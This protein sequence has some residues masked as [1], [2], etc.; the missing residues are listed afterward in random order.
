MTA[1]PVRHV[2][3]AADALADAGAT[4][5]AGHSAHV[6]HGVGGRVL[7]DLGDFLD[8]YR[9]DPRLRNDLGLLF[10]VTLDAAGPLRLEALPLKLEFCH[11]RLASGEDA[12]WM[13]H[14]FRSAC[15]ALGTTVEEAADR[16]IINW[17]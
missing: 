6:P 13:R 17:R 12:A 1:A 5:I 10:L 3:R 8:D 14:R 16:L 7:Y 9:V 4:L 2:R 15:A 11:T